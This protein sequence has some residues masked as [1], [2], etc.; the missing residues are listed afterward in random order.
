MALP[1]VLLDRID[2]VVFDTDGVIT[3]TAQVHAAAWK[4]VF[5]A[6]LRARSKAYGETFRPF[7]VSADY[8]SYVDGKPRND[9]VSAF[10]AARRIVIPPDDRAEVIRR[11]ARRKDAL[12]LDQIRRYG[13]AAF[14]STVVL[15]NELRR[16]HIATAAVSA[17]RNCAE[18]LRRAGVADLFDVRVDGLDAARLGFP[19]KPHPGLFL[20]AARRLR[21][22]PKRTAVVED[23]LAGIVAGRRGGFGL[24]IG[25]DRGG[26]AASPR[27]AGADLVFTDLA[28]LR[29]GWSPHE[30]M[31]ARL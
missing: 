1:V 15:V 26:R 17:S 23:A 14:S 30:P 13:V 25:V 11:I 4:S 20:E 27:E 28:E 10:L 19:G 8:L 5:D 12:F 9:G 29:L 22:P 16:R 3:D 24:V 18:V 7:D 21:V 2:A 6:Y 31:T